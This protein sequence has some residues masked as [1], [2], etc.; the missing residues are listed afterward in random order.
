MLLALI[1]LHIFFGRWNI[2]KHDIEY[3]RHIRDE[4]IFILGKSKDLKQEGFF[5][6]ET[7][8]RAIVRSIE[9]IGEATKNISEE[10]RLKNPAIE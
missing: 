10:F 7:I 8:K 1:S 2:L 3:L 9:V 4:C 5:Q 6:D